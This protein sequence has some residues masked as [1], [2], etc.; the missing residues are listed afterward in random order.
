MARGPFGL[1]VAAFRGALAA[2][3]AVYFLARSGGRMTTVRLVLAGVAMAEV[4]STLAGFLIVTSNDPHKTE[5]A[6]RW[7]LGGIAG[8]TWTRCGYR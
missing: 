5:S 6:L 8:T 4:L 2:S 3:V 7:M 1:P